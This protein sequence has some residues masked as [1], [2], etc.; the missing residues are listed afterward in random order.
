MTL[1]TLL[2]VVAMLVSLVIVST[3]LGVIVYHMKK[4]V[5]SLT[6][7]NITAQKGPL[8]DEVLNMN[9]ESFQENAFVQCMNSCV[10]NLYELIKQ[11]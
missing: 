10:K 5:K 8:I 3:V 9:A 7:I 6:N 11:I 4:S 1:A 2:L